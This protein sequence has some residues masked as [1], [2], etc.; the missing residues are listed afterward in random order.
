MVNR[1]IHIIP[2]HLNLMDFEEDEMQAA[3]YQALVD[4]INTSNNSDHVI[5]EESEKSVVKKKKKRNKRK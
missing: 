2:D 3:M 5:E 4:A 1:H